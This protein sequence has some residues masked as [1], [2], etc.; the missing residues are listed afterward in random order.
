MSSLGLVAGRWTT[1]RLADIPAAEVRGFAA[2]DY[3]EAI[4]GG[5]S[6]E[7]CTPPIWAQDRRAAGA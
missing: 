4:V 3:R 1:A 7:R 2:E 5:R 6:G